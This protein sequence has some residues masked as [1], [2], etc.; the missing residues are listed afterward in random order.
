MDVRATTG[1][2]DTTE[3][4]LTRGFDEGCWNCGSTEHY[5]GAENPHIRYLCGVCTSFGLARK[6]QAEFQRVE[7][8]I[9]ASKKPLLRMR[10]TKKPKGTTLATC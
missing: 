1:G 2:E 8:A 6:A 3:D 10:R 4:E 5:P 9:R 7:E